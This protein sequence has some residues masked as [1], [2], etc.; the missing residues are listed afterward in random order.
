VLRHRAEGDEHHG[1]L[2]AALGF[3]SDAGVVVA[4][5]TWA[6]LDDAFSA[7]WQAFLKA[8]AESVAGGNG[9]SDPAPSAVGKSDEKLDGDELGVS[10][11]DD[12][13]SVLL[14]RFLTTAMTAAE[15]IV[16]DRAIAESVANE[17]FAA[18]WAAGPRDDRELNEAYF[19]RA[20]RN[21][22]LNRT[23]RTRAHPLSLSPEALDRWPSSLPDPDTRLREL[24]RRRALAA[25]LE[26]I[27]P[28]QGMIVYLVD[29]CGWRHQ[30]VAELLGLSLDGV[31]GR[32]RRGLAAL[33]GRLAGDH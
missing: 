25:A 10:W 8:F 23:N 3:E 6:G 9:P 16:R 11:S 22:A 26:G 19:R 1:T 32:R 14:E 15:A 18:V 29:A 33:Q 2:L 24:D 20:A 27:D 7:G 31:R 30:E 13:F 5:R 28:V 4:A 21:R 17:V 12:D